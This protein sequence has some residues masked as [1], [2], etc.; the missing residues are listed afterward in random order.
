MVTERIT[1]S[2][3]DV[4]DGTD[5]KKFVDEM[6]GDKHNVAIEICHDGVQKS[7]KTATSVTPVVIKLTS[8][9]SSS[10]FKN[11]SMHMAALI[12]PHYS[13]LD[14]YLTP[15]VQEL[16]YLRKEGVNI[17]TPSGECHTSRVLVHIVEGDLRALPGFVGMKQ[18]PAEIGCP[19]CTIRGIR[20][21]KTTRYRNGAGPCPPRDT[22]SVTAAND[23]DYGFDGKDRNG[24][25][26]IKPYDERGCN[27]CPLLGAAVP[28]IIGKVA[29]CFAHAAK[30]FVETIFKAAAG[31]FHDSLPPWAVTPAAVETFETRLL[32]I[33]TAMPHETVKSPFQVSTYI[34]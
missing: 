4:Q 18:D 16:V 13:N 5:W 30:N 19:G 6:G 28:D 1:T 11:D 17:S 34:H 33:T 22:G 8:M 29:M 23:A 24:N 32:A 14:I 31:R 27:R 21:N 15:V 2:L 10:R 7:S 9:T 26:I 20:E 12:P 25:A 3:R